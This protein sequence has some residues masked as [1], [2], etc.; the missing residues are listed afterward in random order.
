MCGKTSKRIKQIAKGEDPKSFKSDYL[1]KNKRSFSTHNNTGNASVKG[2]NKKNDDEH[3]SKKIKPAFMSR[4]ADSE[5]DINA[6]NAN[7]R[8]NLKSINTRNKTLVANKQK[9]SVPGKKGKRLG[10]VIKRAMKAQVG[11]KK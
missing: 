6:K 5:T 9:K 3:E 7:K 11:A 1:N 4:K 8:I 2:S 10:G